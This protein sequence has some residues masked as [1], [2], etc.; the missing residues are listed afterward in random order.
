MAQNTVS[1][2]GKWI[3]IIGACITIPLAVIIGGGYLLL[4]QL[5]S[6]EVKAELVRL[7]EDGTGRK[8]AIIGDIHTQLS[9]R[10]SLSVEGI[11]LA[12]APWAGDAPL[13]TLGTLSVQVNIPALFEKKLRIERILVENT[14]LNLATNTKGQ[15]N[16]EMSPKKS[17]TRP[18]KN[19]ESTNRSPIPFSFQ[20]EEL[21]INNTT[22]H[23]K[24]AKTK[25]DINITLPLISIREEQGVKAEINAVLDRINLKLTARA[26]TLDML[27][28]GTADVTLLVDSDDAIH[29]KADGNVRGMTGDKPDFS[30]NTQGDITS[31]APLASLMG[32]KEPTLPA[33]HFSAQLAGSPHTIRISKL[34]GEMLGTSFDGDGALNLQGSTPVIGA[35]LHI[36]ALTLPSSSATGN[37]STASNGSAMTSRMIPDAPL[38]ISGLN[39]VEADI[40][41]NIDAVHGDTSLKDLH[42]TIAL[43]KGT[44]TIDPLSFVMHNTSFKQR[45]TLRSAGTGIALQARSSAAN[46][47][48]GKLLKTLEVNDGLEGGTSN[49]IL[50]LSGNGASVH[51]LLG[52]L[53][54]QLQLYMGNAVYHSGAT[55]QQSAK[56]LELLTGKGQTSDITI[57][58]FATQLPISAGVMRPDWL[59][60][61]TNNARVDGEGSIALPNESLNLKLYPRAT[62]DA[63]KGITFP[64]N[65]SGSFTHPTITPDPTATLAMLAKTA[66]EIKGKGQ[67]VQALSQSISSRFDTNV[68]DSPCLSAPEAPADAAATVENL[69]DYAKEKRD[70]ITQ[71]VKDVKTEIKGIK[72][73]IKTF[74]ETKDINDLKNID[75]Q[76]LEGLKKLF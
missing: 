68:K 7:L 61:Q 59:V 47:N 21:R 57:A 71:T 22:V 36:P 75:L 48:L 37:A 17:S 4:A 62:R 6:A 27:Q 51:G 29:I 39:S 65:I 46:I 50:E 60:F 30:L 5:N 2:D 12:N 38:S 69:K 52:T 20:M 72:E 14:T 74:K 41:V 49:Y 54:G 25:Q 32:G 64:V 58:C 67:N 76:Q 35:K 66:L 40:R 70:E 45:V 42:A 19:A 26:D 44:L 8:A 33:I 10:P 28:Q 31:L 34:Q 55:L 16:W 3:K 1:S 56:W 73:G 11:T 13:I 23:Y 43:H 18:I 24:N 63:L 53:Q 9:L 15:V